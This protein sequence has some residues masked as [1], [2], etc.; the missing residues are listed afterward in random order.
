[1]PQTWASLTLH[2]PGPFPAPVVSGSPK[3]EGTSASFL[4]KVGLRQLVPQAQKGKALF[5]F[6]WAWCGHGAVCAQVGGRDTEGVLRQGHKPP[7]FTFRARGVTA[8][9]SPILPVSA[10]SRCSRFWSSWKWS[11]LAKYTKQTTTV[12][13]DMLIHGT[14]TQ[15]HTRVHAHTQATR[16]THSTPVPMHHTLMHVPRT[17]TP[18]HG[19]SPHT[20][21]KTCTLV[22]ARTHHAHHTRTHAPHT[23]SCTPHTHTPRHGCSLHTTVKT[24]TR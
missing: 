10:P 24:H 13:T 20:T 19:C 2:Q 12:L 7:S 18:R 22:S 17:H 11:L 21:V 6:A 5:P 8:A 1:M 15:W 3:E 23:H 14:W 16:T 4:P 9:A